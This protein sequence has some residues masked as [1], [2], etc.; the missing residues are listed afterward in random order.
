MITQSSDARAH[1]ASL[2][3]V[4]SSTST[5]RSKTRSDG[6]LNV[7]WV[8]AIAVIEGEFRSQNDASTEY[9]ANCCIATQLTS[10]VARAPIISGDP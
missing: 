5:L 10:Q 4:C 8:M 2:E 3:V 1:L 9:L 6:W 7:S